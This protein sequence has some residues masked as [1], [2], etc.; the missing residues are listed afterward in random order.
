[1]KSCTTLT[2]WEQFSSGYV[3]G[4]RFPPLTVARGSRNHKNWGCQCHDVYDDDDDDND[5]DDG[6]DECDDGVMMIRSTR[7]STPTATAATSAASLYHWLPLAAACYYM[8]VAGY[9]SSA[10]Q[11]KRYIL[12]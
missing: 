11:S 12:L 6:K 2:Y 9:F 8:L 4:A 1:M 3:G 5:D 10:T 7:T